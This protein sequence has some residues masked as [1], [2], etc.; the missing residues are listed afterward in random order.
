MS[1]FDFVEYLSPTAS[2]TFVFFSF[3]SFP[4]SRTRKIVQTNVM[5]TF[6]ANTA[7]GLSRLS[8]AIYGTV[9]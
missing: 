3:F 4:G 8:L 9:S 6:A 7:T 5:R 1:S 2:L